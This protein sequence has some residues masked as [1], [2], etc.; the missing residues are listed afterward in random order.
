MPKLRQKSK[1]LTAYLE[2]LLLRYFGQRQQTKDRVAEVYDHVE[3]LTPADPEQ[4]GCQLS[5]RVS[6]PIGPIHSELTKRGVVVRK[7]PK[8]T[9]L[10]ELHP[11]ANLFWVF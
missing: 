2:L 1:A 6:G 7:C 3:I 8:H 11:L 4:R 9:N 10:N 5:I